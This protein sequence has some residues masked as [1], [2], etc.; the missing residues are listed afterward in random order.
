MFPESVW[1]FECCTWANMTNVQV[2]IQEH[3]LTAPLLYLSVGIKVSV[4]YEH[5]SDRGIAE[6]SSDRFRAL[7]L[8]LRTTQSRWGQIGT[9]LSFG[10]FIGA[11]FFCFLLCILQDHPS[12]FLHVCQ[13]SSS[14]RPDISTP[15]PPSTRTHIHTQDTLPAR[16]SSADPPF[17]WVKRLKNGRN[18]EWMRLP[19][20]RCAAWLKEVCLLIWPRM[21]HSESSVLL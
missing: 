20:T 3:T 13:I 16:Y 2:T 7:T 11:S 9:T 19:G 18:G 15:T 6:E 10:S 12:P 8:G 21:Q 5:R 14:W 17:E 4:F 1:G